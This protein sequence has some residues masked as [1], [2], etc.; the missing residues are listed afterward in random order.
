MNLGRNIIN[1]FAVF[2]LLVSSF[3]IKAQ[4]FHFSQYFA[5][6]AN[7][8]PA[9][10]G[11]LE[12]N[13]RIAANYRNQWY[14]VASFTTYAFSVDGNI[15]R[16][17]LDGDNLGIGAS[18][19]QDIEESSSFSNTGVNLTIAYNLKVSQYP[20]QYIGAGIQPGLIRKQININNAVFGNLYEGDPRGNFDPVQFVEHKNLKFDLGVGLSYFLSYKERHTL[21]LGASAFHLTRPNFGT[22]DDDR[23]YMRFM[24]YASSEIKSSKYTA[25]VPTFLFQKQGPSLEFNSG[26]YGR[27]IVVGTSN[28]LDIYAGAQLRLV[29]NESKALSIDA[30]IPGLRFE[31]FKTII[32]FTYDLTISDLKDSNKRNGGPEVSVVVDLNFSSRKKP[33]GLRCPR[34]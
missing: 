14:N 28:E 18:F 8:N 13:F 24:F 4:D 29:G 3:T 7:L 12:G 15:N 2:L 16:W 26:F 10:A 9:L 1:L 21:S 31:F 30:I 6:P 19:Y 33:K 32:G 20:L 5:S 11:V 27:F 22:F 23:L 25:F 17:M 34:F